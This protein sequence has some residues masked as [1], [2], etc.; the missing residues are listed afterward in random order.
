MRIS[1]RIS[2]IFTSRNN[3]HHFF[4]N[5]NNYSYNKQYQLAFKKKKRNES[6]SDTD[7]VLTRLG[8]KA[9]QQ[10][11][12]IYFYSFEIED[13]NASTEH[14]IDVSRVSSSNVHQSNHVH[15]HD[16]F[17]RA[18]AVRCVK[19]QA[20]LRVLCIDG[21]NQAHTLLQSP[22][23]KERSY[24]QEV[25]MRKINFIIFFNINT[26]WFDFF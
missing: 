17:T 24:C 10:C 25:A 9:K 23:E 5:N 15:D 3:H 13:D 22:H 7:S 11:G 1:R 18:E 26:F 21:S 12:I 14:E 8:A 2:N 19:F 6:V 20:I 16:H 4:N